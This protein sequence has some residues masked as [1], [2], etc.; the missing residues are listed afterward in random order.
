[1]KSIYII[2]RIDAEV[3]DIEFVAYTPEVAE[4]FAAYIM[5]RELLDMAEDDKFELSN[6][7]PQQKTWVSEFISVMVEKKTIYDSFKEAMKE[8]E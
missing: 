1:M 3:H 4:E 8:E 2:S 7:L 5:K 6:D